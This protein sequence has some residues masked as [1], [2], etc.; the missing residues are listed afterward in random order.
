MYQNED[1]LSYLLELWITEYPR[2]NS[3]RLKQYDWEEKVIPTQ[4][5]HFGRPRSPK[6]A[7][8]YLKVIEN[9]GE[10]PPIVVRCY[11]NSPNKFKLTDGF[12]R[13]WALRTAGQTTVRAFVGTRKN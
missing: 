8:S 6:K 1:I 4:N 2:Q 12:H 7:L 13:L 5:I 3:S 10:F 9:G 11:K